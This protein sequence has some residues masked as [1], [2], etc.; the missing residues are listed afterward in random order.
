M[1]RQPQCSVL[2]GITEGSRRDAITC[3][4]PCR[5]ARH[6]VSRYV[7]PAPA[8]ATAGAAAPRDASRGPARLAYAD[9]PYPGNAELYR[10]HPDYGGEVDHAAL[11]SQLATFDGWALST[12]A[13]ALPSVLSLA[14]A[15][16]LP[17]RVAGWFRGARPH[18][19]ARFP[20]SAW[21]PVLYVPVA[22]R[23]A[24][25]PRRV[26][27]LVHGVSVMHTLPTRVIGAKPAAFCRWLFDLV[28]A[29]AA[30]ELVDLFPGSGI[31]GKAWELF[32]VSHGTAAERDSMA[33][34]A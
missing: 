29:T 23:R 2:V 21:E 3:S 8:S 12:S 28:G 17:V 22:S 13:A 11:L 6:R 14:V 16:D 27:A 32:Q 10:E 31:V 34:G 25:E 7:S 30:D 4:Q 20:V 26:D 5:Q 19:T 33:E 18:A 15:Q 1:T 9:P 24:G